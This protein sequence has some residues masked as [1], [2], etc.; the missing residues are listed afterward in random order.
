MSPESSTEME[1]AD[2]ISAKC[3]CPRKGIRISSK[4]RENERSPLG[5]FCEHELPHRCFCTEEPWGKQLVAT[6]LKETQVALTAEFDDKQ[7]PRFYE[8]GRFLHCVVRATANSTTSDIPPDMRLH[9]YE[10]RVFN[11]RPRNPIPLAVTMRTLEGYFKNRTRNV[12][13]DFLR[14]YIEKIEKHPPIGEDGNDLDSLAGSSAEPILLFTGPG[15]MIA[16]VYAMPDYAWRLAFQVSFIIQVARNTG[17]REAYSLIREVGWPELVPDVT[18]RSWTE[19][20]RAYIR[21]HVRRPATLE[22]NELHRLIK[23]DGIRAGARFVF[24]NQDEREAFLD[25]YGDLL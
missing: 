19:R 15:Q 3:G 17:S 24:A 2:R 21:E 1:P 13:S 6:Y 9:E 14:S 4:F 8:V 25:H 5:C 7:K 23:R 16:E 22:V 18:L 20:G 10:D 12:H 11:G